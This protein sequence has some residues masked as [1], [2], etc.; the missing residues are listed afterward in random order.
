M[1]WSFYF[2][3]KFHAPD[4]RFQDINTAL[5]TEFKVKNNFSPEEIFQKTRSLKGILEPF[6]TLGNIQM[7]ERSG[8]KDIM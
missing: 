8:F 6:S 7:L 3:E 2:F 4:A 5:Y 1:G